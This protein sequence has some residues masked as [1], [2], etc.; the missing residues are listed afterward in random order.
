LRKAVTR[1]RRARQK[2]QEETEAM[3]IEARSRAKGL[4]TESLVRVHSS[5]DEARL[6]TRSAEACLLA[7]LHSLALARP[8]LASRA[9]SSR[10]VKG[11]TLQREAKRGIFLY[12]GCC[13]DCHSCSSMLSIPPCIAMGLL[14]AIPFLELT[15]MGQERS[16]PANQSLYYPRCIS[17]HAGTGM[18]KWQASNNLEQVLI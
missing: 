9:G 6:S 18:L 8:A 2:E 1:R 7:L 14:Q 16:R 5:L 12:P 4:L 17:L 3:I 15:V 10:V 11:K 13:A